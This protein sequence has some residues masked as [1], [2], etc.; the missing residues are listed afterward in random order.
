MSIFGND[1]IA[2]L[3]FQQGEEKGKRRSEY[4]W[5]YNWGTDV[6]ETFG[7]HGLLWY[8]R[9]NKRADKLIDQFCDSIDKAFPKRDA[10][11]KQVRT[12]AEFFVENLDADT[13]NY[14]ILFDPKQYY[15]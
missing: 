7:Y 4:N 14:I 10:T 9:K 5:H 6:P 15:K 1:W 2:L 3:E 13:K 11:Y 12:L 8:N